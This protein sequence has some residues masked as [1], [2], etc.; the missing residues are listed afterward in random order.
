MKWWINREE[1]RKVMKNDSFFD[2]FFLS[3]DETWSLEWAMM[4]ISTL[5][6]FSS[7]FIDIFFFLLIDSK[8]WIILFLFSIACI[9]SHFLFCLQ[10]FC[11]FPNF[12]FLP[13]FW[14]S[15]LFE[16]RFLLLSGKLVSNRQ[17]DRTRKHLLNKKSFSG[18]QLNV[19]EERE[20]KENRRPPK[21]I[22]ILDE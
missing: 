21:M 16:S 20:R 3:Q 8:M 2:S 15:K 22:K 19:F 6:S 12:C 18:R 4:W 17:G 7:F 11:F 1:G 9:A 5:F 14:N 13:N 10:N